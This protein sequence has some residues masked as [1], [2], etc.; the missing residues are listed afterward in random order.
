MSSDELAELAVVADM[1]ELG[2]QDIEQLH[3]RYLS[4]LLMVALA[5]GVVTTREQADLEL[6]ADLLGIDDPLHLA[7]DGGPLGAPLPEDISGKTVCFT[8]ALTCLHD[9]MLMTR[10]HAAQLA[11]A[12]G[13]IV[14]ARV[15][16]TLDIL[17]VADPETMSGK[18]R[19]ARY[20]GTRIIAET[21]FW[22]LIGVEVT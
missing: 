19:K 6:V 10:H 18:A 2:R 11:A 22:S 14:C 13:L 16:Q 7:L 12:A 4:Q 5:D 21:A 1:Y 17:V 9:G 8:G 20:Y 15:T 3:E